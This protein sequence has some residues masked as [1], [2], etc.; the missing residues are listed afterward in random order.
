WLPERET[1]LMR[2]KEMVSEK[3]AVLCELEA[4]LRQMYDEPDRAGA[5]DRALILQDGPTARLFLRY[6]AEARTAFHRSSHQRLK[7]L[8]ADAEAPVPAAAEAPEA[9]SPNEANPAGNEDGKPDEPTASDTTAVRESVPAG[10]VFEAER[11]END[12]ATPVGGVS[13]PLVAVS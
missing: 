9:V 4:D 13:A 10:G 7:A 8:K 6:H 11:V 3:L 2:L 5:A 12:G 1:C